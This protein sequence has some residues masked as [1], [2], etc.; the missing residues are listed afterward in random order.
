MHLSLVKSGPSQSVACMP[1]CEPLVSGLQQGK[2]D[3]S[4]GFLYLQDKQ[5]SDQPWSLDHTL[6]DPGLKYL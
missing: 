5:S 1:I 2:R 3:A 6:N 4:S